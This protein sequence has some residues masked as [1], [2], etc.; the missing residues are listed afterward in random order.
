MS[1]NQTLSTAVG[2][3][4]DNEIVCANN[5]KV[6]MIWT[7]S[8]VCLLW[9]PQI[10]AQILPCAPPW[11]P[12]RVLGS[13]IPGNHDACLWPGPGHPA[14]CSAVPS[15]P[16]SSVIMMIHHN[17]VCLSFKSPPPHHYI[18]QDTLCLIKP[19][20]LF[21]LKVYL[22]SLVQIFQTC[23]VPFQLSAQPRPR[24][25]GQCRGEYQILW[26]RADTSSNTSPG[27]DTGI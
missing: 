10:S 19:P 20:S 15:S 21:T 1:H 17:W 27:A 14:T 2:Y 23:Q 6:T 9:H 5:E 11:P 8:I 7:W 25:R 22:V 18:T 26:S 3:F 16:P 13:I 24:Q 12:G 4:Y